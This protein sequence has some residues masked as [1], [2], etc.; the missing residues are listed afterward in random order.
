MELELSNK[1]FREDFDHNFFSNHFGKQ[2]LH[3]K[4]LVNN[5]DEIVSLEILDD[6]LSKTNI[7]NNYNFIMMLDQ[8][9]ISYNDYSSLSFDITGSNNRPNVNKVQ[10]LVS[11]GAS[12]ILNDIEK[13]NS[14]LLRVA[15][16]LQKLTHGRCQGNL[17]FSMAS[18]QAF[19]PHF[20][21]HDVFAIHFEG[22]KIWNIYENIENSPINHP[23][24][25]IPPE[26]RVQ[27]AGKLIDQVTLNP[28]DLL[29]I[30]RGQYH[31]ALAS[32]DGAI[33][34]AFGLTY[35]KPIDLMSSIW[36]KFI[37]NQFM[38]N[39]IKQ[40]SSKEELKIILSK[41][42]KEIGN[43]IETD[44]TLGILENNLKNW[45]YP[46]EEY[47]IKNL[48]L[49]GTRYDLSKTVKFHKRDNKSFLISGSNEVL[50]PSKF[51]K[52]TEFIFS[53]QYIT[54]KLLMSEFK[55]IS[56]KEIIECINNL[57]N[58]KVLY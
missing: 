13:Y 55:D 57:K 21:L 52:I 11:K 10:K 17:Y 1:I 14:N 43:I 8:K 51:E 48:V 24:F 39:D 28:G 49:E 35:F 20:D 31:D 6:L 54:E 23:A 46:I 15:D 38:R 30:P 27:R 16:E 22:K 40:N 37:L 53:K 5:F 45:P 36:E 12:I 41:F 42:S 58:M 34:V 9:K 26:E 56:R 32:E 25:R 3:K 47:S 44:E 2:Y 19:G 50:V 33:H 18:H 7:W 4:N 29:Y